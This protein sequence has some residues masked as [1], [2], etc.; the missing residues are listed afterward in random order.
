MLCGNLLDGGKFAETVLDRT[1]GLVLMNIVADVI[2]M[3][4]PLLKD[5][6]KGTVVCSGI[7]TERLDQVKEALTQNGFTVDEVKEKNGWA[8]VCASR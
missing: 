7:I 4:L 6:V 2:I 5:H 1:Y 3:M 8:V